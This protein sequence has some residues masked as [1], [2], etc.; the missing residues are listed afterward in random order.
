MK[1]II[2]G[3]GFTGGLLAKALVA[4]RNN[5]VLIDNNAE[6]VRSVGDQLDCTVIEAD[7]NSIETLEKAGISS[8]DALVALT[9]NDEANM[10]VCSLVDAIYP[11]I[12][13]IARVRNY[14]YY[15]RMMDVAKR[16]G[17]KDLSR[18]M[19]GIDHVI[20][21]DV[22]AAG[23]MMR[24]MEIGAA[25]SAV[26]L[27][28]DYGIVTLPVIEGSPIVGKK[29][30][31]LSEIEGWKFLI[32]FVENEEGT[33]L[34]NGETLLAA[35]DHIGVLVHK[36]S[37]AQL[38]KYTSADTTPMNRIVIFGADNISALTV[39][40]QMEKINP[41]KK[42]FFSFGR[43]KRELIVIDKDLKRCNELAEKFP[44]ARILNGDIT[45]DG[46]IQGEGICNCDLMVAA[47][48]NYE[49]NLL[50]SAYLK[51]R[52]VKKVISL[53]SDS[54]F[55][56]IAGKLGVDVTVPMRDVVI[57]TIMSHLRGRNI[58]AV[59]S[60]GGRKFEIVSCEIS[61]YSKVAGKKLSEIKGLENCLV[62]LVQQPGSESREV[63]CGNTVMTA[64]ARVVLIVPSGDLDTMKKFAGKTEIEV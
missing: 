26:E 58:K 56:E 8:A 43:A 42:R 47:S 61:L 46:L 12:L 51:L 35:G 49:R 27:G 53:T 29:L 24:A 52:G 22:E 54:A 11:N 3:A 63:P 38:L 39:A 23:S 60:V 44:E 2:I 31:N 36:E 59:H 50:T 5:V 16:I 18:A 41:M 64:G 32:A 55:D 45:D 4:E 10:I 19:L 57:D 14:D 30:R 9:H 13:K 28:G 7:G 62:L 6:L 37:V 48:G 21:P 15:M 1:I 33:F 25:G 17:A 34:A 40:A 20:N